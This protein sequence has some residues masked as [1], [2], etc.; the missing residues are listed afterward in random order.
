[1]LCTIFRYSELRVYQ[2]I[3]KYSPPFHF[4][5]TSAVV[6]YV[7]PTEGAT[8]A[9]VHGLQRPPPSVISLTAGLIDVVADLSD[10][11]A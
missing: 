2:Y 1:M 3:I 10:Q 4:P 5:E 11:A 8:K 9:H 6:P 7:S